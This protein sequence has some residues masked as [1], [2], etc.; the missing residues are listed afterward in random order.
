M[1]DLIRRADALALFK[2]P[3]Q[4]LA[5]AE[6]EALPAVTVCDCRV[7]DLIE[8]LEEH[9]DNIHFLPV[10]QLQILRDRLA[11]LEPVAAPAADW[12]STTTKTEDGYNG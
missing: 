8:F 11:A 6:V 9:P 7:R 3:Y 4:L 1:S 2:M 12:R 5:K 10:D